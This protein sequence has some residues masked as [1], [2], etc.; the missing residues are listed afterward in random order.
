VNFNDWLMQRNCEVN[1]E[2]YHSLLNQKQAEKRE[3]K[4]QQK[5]ARNKVDIQ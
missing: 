5:R 1:V 4:G 2:E 3:N